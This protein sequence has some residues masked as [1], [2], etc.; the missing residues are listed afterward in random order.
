MSVIQGVPEALWTKHLLALQSHEI[1]QC[2]VQVD[3]RSEH[4]CVRRNDKIPTESALER[5]VRYAER[6]VLVRLVP[7]SQ[8]VRAFADTPRNAPFF[9]ICNLASHRGTVCLVDER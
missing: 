8:V 9:A 3:H 5:E 7:V 1:V 2:T 4:R 6:S